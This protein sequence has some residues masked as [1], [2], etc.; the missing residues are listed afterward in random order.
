M[1]FKKIDFHSSYS[2]YKVVCFIQIRVSE[3]LTYVLYKK[4]F[5]LIC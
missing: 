2:K 3:R 4:V 5:I 1:P